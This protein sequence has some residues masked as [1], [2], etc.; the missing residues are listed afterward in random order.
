MP[1]LGFQ[2]IPYLRTSQRTTFSFMVRLK[3]GEIRLPDALGRRMGC[4]SSIAIRMIKGIGMPRKYNNI[5]R[6]AS[7][8]G[9][10]SL[11]KGRVVFHRRLPSDW[12]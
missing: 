4:H 10:I 12:Q 5:E 3:Q 6:I 8:L 11:I 9:L 2:R 7:L 1:Q